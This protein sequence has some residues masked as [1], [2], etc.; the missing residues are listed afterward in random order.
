MVTYD[1]AIF[2]D[3]TEGEGEPSELTTEQVIRLY[4]E[5][6]L[7]IPLTRS[8]VPPS[9][10]RDAIYAEAVKWW[11]EAHAEGREISLPFG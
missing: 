7:S 3:D 4:V 9:A 10:E 8:V 5:A 6:D 1:P 2:D 11:A